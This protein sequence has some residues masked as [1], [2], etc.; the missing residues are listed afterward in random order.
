MRQLVYIRYCPAPLGIDTGCKSSPF[1]GSRAKASPF[2]RGSTRQGDGEG[3]R[4]PERWYNPAECAQYENLLG[5]KE[6]QGY[7][8]HCNLVHNRKCGFALSVTCGDSSPKGG[9]FLPAPKRYAI[10][11]KGSVLGVCTDT[12]RYTTVS[13]I[14]TSWHTHWLSDLPTKKDLWWAHRSFLIQPPR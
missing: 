8:I 5:E 12:E 13:R 10:S 9:A 4:A 2:G 14:P 3:E 11:P 7:S 6:K 1:W